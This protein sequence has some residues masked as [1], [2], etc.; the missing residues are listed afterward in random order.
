MARLTEAQK[1]ANKRE[2]A[3]RDKAYRARRHEYEQAKLAAL[4][5]FWSTTPLKAAKDRAHEELDAA[6]KA[7]K[8]EEMALLDQ[9]HA[10]QQKIK[11]LPAKYRLDELN[12]KR[13]ETTDAYMQA[14]EAVESAVNAEFSDIAKVWSAV[15]WA[16]KVGFRA[17]E[18]A[19]KT[20]C[21]GAPHAK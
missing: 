15:E 18:N 17:S 8:Q 1:A 16:H 13:R 2:V 7:S 10:L 11:A 6:H 12:Q 19:A 4:N 20:D 5:Q 3:A 9:I 14:E 21:E